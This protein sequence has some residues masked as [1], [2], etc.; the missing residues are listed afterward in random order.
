MTEPTSA[1]T[2]VLFTL[3]SGAE[4]HVPMPPGGMTSISE[5]MEM[6]SGRFGNPVVTV[7][8]SSMMS[9]GEPAALIMIDEI[10]AV[11]PSWG[12]LLDRVI[13]YPRTS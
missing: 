13:S 2:H 9:I 6:A 4:V 8:S 3:K 11:Q 10:A 7:T 5:R 12:G 1:P